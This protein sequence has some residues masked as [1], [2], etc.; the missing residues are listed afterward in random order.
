[1]GR[2]KEDRTSTA[3]HI[4]YIHQVFVTGSI[5]G[6]NIKSK[7]A[8]EGTTV[9][10]RNLILYITSD[11]NTGPKMTRMWKTAAVPVINQID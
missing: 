7:H 9:L 3:L 1:M 4:S 8:C 6:E 10:V 2:W 11:R 5:G